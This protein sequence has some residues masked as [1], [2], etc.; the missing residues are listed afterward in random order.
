MNAVLNQL[1]SYSENFL[2]LPAYKN[3]FFF[4]TIFLIY[5]LPVDKVTKFVS[6]S[7]IT[8]I[9]LTSDWFTYLFFNSLLAESISSYFF[10]VLF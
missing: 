6:S 10:G 3:L 1:F 8:V 9:V 5:E 2:Y 7:I 4:L